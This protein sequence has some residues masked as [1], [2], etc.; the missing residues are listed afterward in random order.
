MNK[1]VK[2]S[3]IGIS[4]MRL[5]IEMMQYK[6][7]NVGLNVILTEEYLTCCYSNLKIFNLLS[8]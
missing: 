7:Q 8:F 3:F 6:A 1:N 2:Q 5:F 4:P